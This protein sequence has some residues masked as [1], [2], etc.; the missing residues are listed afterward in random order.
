M[1]ERELYATRAAGLERRGFTE[2]GMMSLAV[3]AGE[4]RF[5]EAVAEFEDKRANRPCAQ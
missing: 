5:A 3:L 4:E 1:R 2:Y